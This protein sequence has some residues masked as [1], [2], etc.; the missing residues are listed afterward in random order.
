M[1]MKEIRFVLTKDIP[2]YKAW[3]IYNMWDS[4]YN[5]KY[6]IEEMRKNT[7]FFTEI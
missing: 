7:E 6:T 2:D 3:Y 4:P 1:I 5:W